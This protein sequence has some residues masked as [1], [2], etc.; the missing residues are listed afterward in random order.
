MLK[1]LSYSSVNTY[2]MCPRSWRYRYIDKAPAP[3]STSLIFGSAFH[4][5]LEDF[6]TRDDSAPL[7]AIWCERWNAKIAE[8][9]DIAWDSDSPE[10]LEAVG[11]KMFTDADI[12]SIIEALRPADSENVERFVELRVPGVPVPVIGYI[13][14]IAGNGIPCDFKTASRKWAAGKASEEMQPLFYLA[15]LNQAGHDCDMRFRHYVFTK[16]KAPALQVFDT[17]RTIAE[18]VWLFEM[19]REVWQS[20][21]AQVF[22]PNPGTWKCSEK[23]CEY[24]PVCRGRET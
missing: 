14:Y 19:I 9:S 16:T 24:W 23:W 11:V 18:I 4:D 12:V 5:T 21:E 6:I 13:D 1:H 10:G 22:M 20:I 8:E 2:L 3:T 7:E 17:Q 15:A